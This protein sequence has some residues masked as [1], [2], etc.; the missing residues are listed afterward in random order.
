MRR[1]AR[2]KITPAR[3]V[4]LNTFLLAAVRWLGCEHRHD[5]V[6]TRIGMADSILRDRAFRGITRTNLMR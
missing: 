5:V 3:R 6:A 1:S 4:Y 2:A